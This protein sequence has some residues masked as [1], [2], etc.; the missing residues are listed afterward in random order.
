MSAF[1]A[2]RT[3]SR[4]HR[5]RFGEL[6]WFCH[7]HDACHLLA[8]E[9]KD[10]DQEVFSHS[11][12]SVGTNYQGIIDVARAFSGQESQLFWQSASVF[13]F[14]TSPAKAGPVMARAMAIANVEMRTF[15]G[16]SPLRWTSPHR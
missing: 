4:G 8:G 13:A 1:G 15:M 11:P 3:V 7:I 16:F 2:K 9:Q 14:D 10:C 12:G 5:W 6:S